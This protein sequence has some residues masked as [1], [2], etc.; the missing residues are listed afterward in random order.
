MEFSGRMRARTSETISADEDMS[1]KAGWLYAD[2]FLAL[3]VIFLATIS[4]VP[5]IRQSDQDSNSVRIQS[6]TI[7]QSTNYNFDQ[8]L[9]LLLSA[10]D[11]QLISSRI[12]QFLAE[13][14]LPSDAEV[15]FMK[16]IGGFA[17]NPSG[18]S[19]ATTRAI[20]YG[21]TLKNE[22]PELFS[23][24][25]L[26]VDISDSVEDGKVALVLTFAAVPR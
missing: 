25:T 11:G 10:P 15:V 12:T 1:D 23:L 14:K 16:L 4:F 5:E 21:M 19:A 13:S 18:E 8:G 22:N 7:K 3:M 24:A 17:N 20:K 9:T 2:L 26:S 6:S